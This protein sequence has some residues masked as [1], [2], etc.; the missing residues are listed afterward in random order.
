MELHYIPHA[1]LRMRRRVV[2][3]SE[4]EAVLTSPDWIEAEG[5]CRN[6]Y[7]ARI[8]GRLIEVVVEFVLDPPAVITVV[9]PEEE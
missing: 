4:V 7:Q 8:D 6:L 1:I 3:I 5:G 2:S 9:A